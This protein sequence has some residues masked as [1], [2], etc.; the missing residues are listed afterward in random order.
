MR[1][2]FEKVATRSC[3]HLAEWV[4]I[5][6]IRDPPSKHGELVNEHPSQFLSTFYYLSTLFLSFYARERERERESICIS[7]TV[8]SRAQ[9]FDADG[10]DCRLCGPR[11]VP[12]SESVAF[13]YKRKRDVVGE[14]ACCGSCALSA[15]PSQPQ[16]THHV[17]ATAARTGL[18][19]QDTVG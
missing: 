19:H 8:D 4:C 16:H 13:V 15:T 10:S 7:V 1:C 3:A 17:R 2:N 12:G 6:V 14:V 5:G 11:S 9:S 18:E